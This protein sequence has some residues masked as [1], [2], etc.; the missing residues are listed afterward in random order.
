MPDILGLLVSFAISNDRVVLHAVS[1]A[2]SFIGIASAYMLALN[3]HVSK[4]GYVVWLASNAGWIAVG[5]LMPN[6]ALVFIQL[7]FVAVNIFGIVRWFQ[8]TRGL[9]AE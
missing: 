5:M 7:V 4:W 2:A 6:P 1:W 3:S 9:D 8:P